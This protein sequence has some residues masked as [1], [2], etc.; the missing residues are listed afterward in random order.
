MPDRCGRPRFA[1]AES[2]RGKGSICVR[3]VQDSGAESAR[4]TVSAGVGFLPGIVRSGRE[5]VSGEGAC[6]FGRREPAFAGTDFG[7]AEARFAGG[8]SGAAAGAEVSGFGVPRAA[9]YRLRMAS[10]RARCAPDIDPDASCSVCRRR[11]HSF[12]RDATSLSL[13]ASPETMRE[14]RERHWSQTVS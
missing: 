11:S 1:G 6:V 12:S 2:L 10:K 8:V 4:G 5:D 14:R 13:T 3:P 9:A 7:A